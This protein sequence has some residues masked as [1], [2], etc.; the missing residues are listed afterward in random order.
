MKPRFVPTTD[1]NDRKILVGCIE[2]LGNNGTS[3]TPLK[4]IPPGI[5]SDLNTESLNRNQTS[6][7]G[8]TDESSSDEIRTEY[9]YHITIKLSYSVKTCVSKIIPITEEDAWIICENK[10]YKLKG[11]KL[12]E[13]LYSERV[14]DMTVLSDG[15]VILL[16]SQDKF[17]KRL[18]GKR[19]LNFFNYGLDQPMCIKATPDDNVIVLVDSSYSMSAVRL[20]VVQLDNLG[21]VK[22]QFTFSYA[23]NCR[24]IELAVQNNSDLYIIINDYSSSPRSTIVRVDL[25]SKKLDANNTFTGA[26]GMNASAHFICNGFVLSRIINF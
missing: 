16:N 13:T 8:T 19:I 4:L 25:K 22:S 1:I 18:L 6:T 24:P 12:E 17:I 26:I 3:N 2:I 21:I 10:L 9:T 5:C 20:D 14:D 11:C 15:S 23:K 7:S